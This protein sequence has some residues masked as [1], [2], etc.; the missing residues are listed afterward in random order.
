[1]ALC[2]LLHRGGRTFE[3]AHCNFHLRPGECDRDEQFVRAQA[4]RYGA[5][6]HVAQFDTEAYAKEHGI[7][8]EMAARELRYRYFEQIRKERG[9]DY[10]AVGHHQD[11][12]EETFF[13]NLMRGTGIAGLHGIRPK[14]GCIVRPMLIFSRAEIDQFVEN[15]N[16]PYVEDHTNAELDYKRNKI[17]HKL[18]PLLRE[19]EPNIDRILMGDMARLA[20]AETIYKAAI[21]QRIESMESVCEDGSIRIG[22][23]DIK[24]LEPQRTLTYELLHPYGFGESVTDQLLGCLDGNP[25]KVFLSNTHQIT[26]DRNAIIITPLQREE[27]RPKIDI[28]EPI[29][30]ERLDSFKTAPNVMLCDA[31]KLRLPLTLRHWRTG[32]KFHPFGM[33]GAKLVS[34]YFTDMKLSLID[35]EKVWLLCDAEG[36]IM[37]IIGMRTDDRFKIS[38]HTENAVRIT[39][40]EDDENEEKFIFK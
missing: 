38:K 9:L 28:S 37:W 34:D 7:S 26:K 1:M 30:I 14:N 3:I 22:I 5:T 16:L 24:A 29:A 23:D 31:A 36:L 2:E 39:L 13:L 21:K 25:G 35:K 18:M 20:D 10:I 15:N 27:K 4:Q 12:A 8:I 19:L 33:S 40:I 11:D 32:D 6:I 17:R